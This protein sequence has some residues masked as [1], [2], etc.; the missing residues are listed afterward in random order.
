MCEVGRAGGTFQYFAVPPRV[1]MDS[2]GL[3]WTPYG[4]YSKHRCVLKRTIY[5]TRLG[6]GLGFF[7]VWVRVLLRVRVRFREGYTF[8][9]CIFGLGSL[10]RVR[11]C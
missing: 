11:D 2:S 6:F 10:V 7:K 4:L 3:Q 1:H 5:G 8:C 9:V